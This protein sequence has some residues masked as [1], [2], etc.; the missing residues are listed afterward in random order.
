MR[1]KIGEIFYT[2]RGP[3]FP[4]WLSVEKRI[5]VRASS[6]L[7]YIQRVGSKGTL[8]YKVMFTG[9]NRIE[10]AVRLREAKRYFNG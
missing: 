1:G 10:I 5:D 7:G 2:R 8:H 6:R 3:D 4:G 9:S